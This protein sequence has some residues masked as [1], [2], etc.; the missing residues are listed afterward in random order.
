MFFKEPPAYFMHRWLHL[1]RGGCCSPHLSCTCTFG[2]SCNIKYDKDDQD[3]MLEKKR[4]DS[5]P[6]K[7][8]VIEFSDVYRLNR[9]ERRT[10]VNMTLFLSGK[11][12]GLK[13]L[14]FSIFCCEQVGVGDHILLYILHLKHADH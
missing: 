5:S 2:A 7:I 14:M 10:A 4:K 9:S 6:L 12:S 8:P 11:V 1:R 3:S 13:F